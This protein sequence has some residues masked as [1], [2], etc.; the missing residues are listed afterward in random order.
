MTNV[1]KIKHKPRLLRTTYQPNAPY[2]LERKDQD[3]GTI[4][5]LIYDRRPESYHFI[6]STNDEGGTDPNAK[7]D[8]ER[9]VRGLNLLVQYGLEK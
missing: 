4:C 2:V 8:A 5:Y 6:C 7:R 1:V 3:D 9:I